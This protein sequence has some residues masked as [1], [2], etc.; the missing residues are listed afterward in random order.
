MKMTF[1]SRRGKQ[2]FARHPN[3]HKNYISSGRIELLQQLRVIA[4]FATQC[5]V[6]LSL[7]QYTDGTAN[8]CRIVSYEKSNGV[9]IRNGINQPPL[10]RPFNAATEHRLTYYVYSFLKYRATDLAARSIGS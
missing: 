6:G 1:V 8:G 10:S 7:K 4:S 5:D 2:V 3:I 9:P